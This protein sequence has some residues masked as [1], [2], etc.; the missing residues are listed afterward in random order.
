MCMA[1]PSGAA[2][3]GPAFGPGAA[4][5]HM[6]GCDALGMRTP[7]ETLCMSL[8]RSATGRG[9]PLGAAVPFAG[10]SGDGDEPH[11][12]PPGVAANGPEVSSCEVAR[13]DSC[14][15]PFAVGV[16]GDAGTEPARADAPNV[17]LLGVAVA[18]DV[19]AYALAR[20]LRMQLANVASDHPGTSKREH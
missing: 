8:A 3:L 16:A 17:C 20:D 4:A 1:R 9:R 13:A 15:M 12:T 18:C 10:R 11:T 6:P 7:A 2:Q 5:V 14:S 19:A